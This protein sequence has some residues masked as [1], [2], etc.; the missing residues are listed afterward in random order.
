MREQQRLKLVITRPGL[1]QQSQGIVDARANPAPQFFRC[2][3]GKGDYQDFSRASTLENM[4]QVEVGYRIGLAGTGAG[5][6]QLN[7]I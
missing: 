5:L 7:A 3:I 2:R 4:S 6:Y 1:V